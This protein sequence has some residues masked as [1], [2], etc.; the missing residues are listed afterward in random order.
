MAACSTKN[1]FKVVEEEFPDGKPMNVKY[2]ASETKEKLIREI[3]YYDD[4]AVYI[5]GSFKNNERHG[6][7]VAYY[8]DGVIWSQA[9]YKDGLEDGLKSVYFENGQKYYEGIKEKNKRVG[10]WKF[11]DIEGNLVKEVNYDK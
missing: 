8:K 7:W 10:I 6:S 4:G 5:E 3:Q 2:F 11:W 1:E 9:E